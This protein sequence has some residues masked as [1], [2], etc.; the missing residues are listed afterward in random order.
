MI[1]GCIKNMIMVHGGADSSFETA[2][3]VLRTDTAETS[4]GEEDMVAEANRII[5]ELE[6][7][8]TK[9]K[10]QSKKREIFMYFLSFTAGA[11]MGSGG[12]LL[13]GLLG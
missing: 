2:Y 4:A 10:K 6:S 7:G 9:K 13:I 11:V 12:A 3:F 8:D 5:E 1:K